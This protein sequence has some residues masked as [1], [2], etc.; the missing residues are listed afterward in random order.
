MK[1]QRELKL[2]SQ[3]W[4]AIETINKELP[5]DKWIFFYHFDVKIHKKNGMLHAVGG[6]LIDKYLDQIGLF[7]VLTTKKALNFT[8]IMNI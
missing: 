7:T 5:L 8:T 4:T 2:S 1:D 6:K 3:Y